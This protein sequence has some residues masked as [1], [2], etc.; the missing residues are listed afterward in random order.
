MADF[1]R[2]E[3]VLHNGSSQAPRNR[4]KDACPLHRRQKGSGTKHRES[5]ENHDPCL[6]RG[7]NRTRSAT[8]AQDSQRQE[9]ALAKTKGEAKAT[10]EGGCATQASQEEENRMNPTVRG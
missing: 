9:N 4:P 3:S 2:N 10:A 1:C 6:D 7:G 5:R 8:P